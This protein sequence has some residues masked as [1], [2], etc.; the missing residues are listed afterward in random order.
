MSTCKSETYNRTALS[1]TKQ[2]NVQE[3]RASDLLASL[4]SHVAGKDCLGD[5]DGGNTA[6][7]AVF[8]TVMGAIVAVLQ[9]EW[10]HT[11]REYC[12]DGIRIC[13]IPAAMGIGGN[14]S[15]SKQTW[16]CKI[17]KKKQKVSLYLHKCFNQ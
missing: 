12:G 1:E 5:G 11:P 14:Y 4:T 13:C 9:R 17:C 3:G 6:V 8:T 2:K 16:C 7:T 15:I 10:G